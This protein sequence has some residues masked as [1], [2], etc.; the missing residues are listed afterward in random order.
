MR[1][2][3]LSCRGS[4]CLFRYMDVA[5][6]FGEKKSYKIYKGGCLIVPTMIITSFL[7]Q[8]EERRYVCWI[9]LIPRPQNTSLFPSKWKTAINNSAERAIQLQN[10]EVCN[11]SVE[12]MDLPP[13]SLLCRRPLLVDSP[14]TC[15]IGIATTITTSINQSWIDLNFLHF[16]RFRLWCIQNP[17]WTIFPLWTFFISS[18]SHPHF[19]SQLL[20]Y[21]P[22]ALGKIPDWIRFLLLLLLLGL[23]SDLNGQQQ[24][25]GSLFLS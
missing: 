20:L 7:L 8:V 10:L 17:A 25:K 4:K 1:T 6:H 13:R 19:I 24:W 2:L 21:D 12:E 16:H 11:K 5:L 3:Y 15:P 23:W 14:G 22:C 9:H 18:F